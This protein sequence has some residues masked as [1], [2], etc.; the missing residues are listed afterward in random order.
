MLTKCPHCQ[1]SY[2]ITPTDI[3]RQSQCSSCHATFS[4]QEDTPEPPKPINKPKNKIIDIKIQFFIPNIIGF[5]T[6]FFVS[7][8]LVLGGVKFYD[9][10]F[11]FI[12][13]YD[14]FKEFSPITRY[15]SE[16]RLIYFC[17]S[18][19][20]ILFLTF[21]VYTLCVIAKHLYISSKL[22]REKLTYDGFKIFSD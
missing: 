17:L 5:L 16:L 2:S 8:I 10:C 4:I 11:Y 7:F 15:I 9:V 12:S 13:E 14:V 18:T 22:L 21:F 6:V 20:V 19:L 1:A 3:G